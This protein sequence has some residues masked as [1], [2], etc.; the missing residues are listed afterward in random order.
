M[1]APYDAA[2]ALYPLLPQWYELI[3]DGVTPEFRGLN[4]G[5]LPVFGVPL[6]YTLLADEGA[7]E[8]GHAYQKL[9]E[10]DD[11]T[12][13]YLTAYWLFRGFT[14]TWQQALAGSRAI[15]NRPATSQDEQ[16][17]NAN[18]AWLYDPRESWAE[19][20][21]RSVV[22]AHAEKTMNFGKDM[23]PLL[24]RAF[25]Q[26][27]DTK[28][29][30]VPVGPAGAVVAPPAITTP[31]G[32]T[33][34]VLLHNS[35]RAAG[36]ID[37]WS[38]APGEAQYICDILNPRIVSALARYGIKTVCLDG[39]MV[40][41]PEYTTDYLC[42]LAPHYDADVYGSGGWFWGRAALS[43]THV[44]DDRLGAIIQRRYAALNGPAYHPERLNVNVTDYY[45]F[46][47]TND[48]TPGVLVELGVGWGADKDWLRANADR[49]AQTLADS[50]AEFAGIA[51]GDMAFATDPDAIAYRKDVK[52]TLDAIKAVLATLATQ[53]KVEDAQLADV[54]AR[55]NKLHSI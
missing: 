38:G 24:L 12:Y 9:L 50:I 47:W 53:N 18:E 51:G 25:F 14:G 41:H 20:F 10:R 36:K 52:D 5:G 17:R 37:G 48:K 27:L 22:T 21:A 15:A 40:F 39:D 4:A 49:I 46:R 2:R 55:I 33:L 44:A 28:P 45:A 11:S 35:H 54:T 16:R 3:E 31:A 32:P 13:D 1:R 42:F 26:S 29:A 6:H 43:P 23:N 7:H 30:I 8:A 19:A 34:P